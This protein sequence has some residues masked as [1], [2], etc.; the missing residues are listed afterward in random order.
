MGVDTRA[1]IKSNS[2]SMF[3]FIKRFDPSAQMEVHLF[4]K[5]DPDER[6]M[7]VINFIFLGEQRLLHIHDMQFGGIYVKKEEDWYFKKYNVR[8]ESSSYLY[9][10]DGIPDNT[11][12]VICSLGMWGLSIEIMNLLCIEFGGWIDESDCDNIGFKKGA[13][14]S[15][16]R[17]IINNI[18]T[19][20]KYEN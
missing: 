10:E 4:G 1:F 20:Y 15:K 5:D 3:E 19:K 6:K 17:E 12:G 18:F 13:T 14:K 7:Y 2:D 16:M 11:A 8:E 9:H